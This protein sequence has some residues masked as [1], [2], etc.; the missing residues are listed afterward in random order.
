MTDVIEATAVEEPG[1]DVTHTPAPSPSTLFRTSEP[2]EVLK[3]ATATANALKPVLKSQGMLST[4]EGRDFVKIEGWTT[5]GSMLGVTP[6][7]VWTRKLENGWEA[8]VNAQTLDG[9]VIGSA[10]AMCVKDEARWKNADEYAIRSMAQTRAAS[11][12]L[13][14]VLRFVVTLAGFSGTPAEEMDGVR[15]DSGG[16]RKASAKQL[17]F[18]E[19]L[20]K[21]KVDGDTGQ[22]MAYAAANFT[23]GKGGS[24]SKV[25]EK[26]KEKDAETIANLPKAASEW[27]AKQSDIPGDTTGLEHPEDESVPF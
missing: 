11:K 6:V 26:L 23:G 14:S 10:E 17:D 21:E 18:L 3:A 19:T 16:P 7:G 22:I 20:V 8:K 4:I 27:A 2:A 25:I 13:A 9:R 5:L 15:S 24:C 12:A 1:T